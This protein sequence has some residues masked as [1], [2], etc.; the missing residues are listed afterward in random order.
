MQSYKTGKQASLFKYVFPYYFFKVTETRLSPDVAVR[1]HVGVEVGRVTEGLVAD[2]ALVGR[3]RA[4]GRL[5]LLEVSFL[6]ETF[7]ADRALERTFA[8][9]TTTTTK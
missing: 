6:T 7:V 8:C 4:V 2:G 5:V 3:G 9:K 1:G